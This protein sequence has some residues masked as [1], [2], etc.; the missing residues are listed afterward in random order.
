VDDSN[1]AG[2]IPVKKATLCC[3]HYNIEIQTVPLPDFIVHCLALC[4]MIES[5]W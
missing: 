2:G 4:T 5:L 3:L 1:M